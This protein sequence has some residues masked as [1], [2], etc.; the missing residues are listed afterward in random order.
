MRIGTAGKWIAVLLHPPGVALVHDW[1]DRNRALVDLGISDDA[2]V[3]GNPEARA[4][5][6]L[7]LR[8]ELGQSVRYGVV[9]VERELERRARIELDNPQLA[10]PNVHRATPIRRQTCVDRRLLVCRDA[11]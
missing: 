8:D 7:L 10:A 4:A 11:P 5:P 9:C 2:A 6:H 1:V 3:G